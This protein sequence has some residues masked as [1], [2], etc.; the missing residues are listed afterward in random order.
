MFEYL[1]LKKIDLILLASLILNWFVHGFII[2]SSSSPSL[3]SFTILSSDFHSSDFTL[4][5]ILS[6]ICRTIGKSQVKKPYKV[7]SLDDTNKLNNDL[8]SFYS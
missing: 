7:R 6:D 4:S 2:I 8:V 3:S 5:L 1:F